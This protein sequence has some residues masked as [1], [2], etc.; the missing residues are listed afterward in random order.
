MPGLAAVVCVAGLD[1][2]VFA[3]FGDPVFYIARH[4][5]VVLNL[6]LLL[7]DEDRFGGRCGRRSTL[8][9]GLDNLDYALFHLS[10]FEKKIYFSIFGEWARV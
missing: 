7:L 2:A 1:E 3:A 10:I 4:V 6:V 8:R 5:A 9:S